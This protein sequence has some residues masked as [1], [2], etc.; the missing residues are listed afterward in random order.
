MARR[1]ALLAALA[2][3]VLPA[4]AGAATPARFFAGDAGRRSE[5]GHPVARRPRRRARRHRRAGLRQARGRR[6]PRLRLAA[7]QRRLPAARADRRRAGRRRLAA[8]RGG[9]GRRPAGRRLRERRRLFTAVRP[10]GAPGYAAA[11]RSPTPAPNPD[12]DMSIN[13]VGL[14]RPGRR[15]GDVQA[16]RLERNATTLQRR[17]AARWTSTRPRPPATGTG[18]PKVAVAADGVATVVWGESGHVYA[19][20]MFELRLSTAPQDLGEDA[21]APDISSEDDSSFAWVVFRQDGAGHRPPAR[22]LA[23]RPPGVDP[24]RRGRPTR[25]ASPSTGAASATPGV[26]GA[27]HAGAYGAVL[28]D[29]LFNPGVLLGGGFGAAPA[30]VPAVA[31]TG[32]GLVAFSRATRAA[33]A[34]STRGPTTTSPASRAVTAPGP[35]ATL[36]DPALGPTDAARGL[37]AAAD[38]AG[39]VAVAFVQG[40]GDARRIVAG[41][42]R[43]RP[44]RVP[45]QHDDQVAQVRA[46]PA[47]VGDGV[48]AV[49]AVDL[50]A[51]RSTAKPV[52]ADDVHGPHRADRACPTGCIAGGSSPSTSAARRRRRPRAT[53]ASTRRRPRSP[54]RSRGRASAASR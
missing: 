7:G 24:G 21:D 36:S 38:R 28:K 6:R 17:A 40:D 54:S 27:T 35:D 1:I 31:E 32:D 49:G 45:R 51:C 44:R 43:P 34:R 26:G 30:A 14:P 25:R 15:G 46:A 47:E 53:C 33:D 29:D 19:R 48:R 22:R 8:G 50:P 37:E 41:Q 12:V 39:D 4:V 20:R 16:A 18:R 11:S 10:A 23:V 52:G 5:R 2:S 42:L 3:L 9:V 13:G